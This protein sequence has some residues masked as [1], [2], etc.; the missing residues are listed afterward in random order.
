MHHC[1]MCLHFLTGG[2]LRLI[3]MPGYGVDAFLS[4][5]RLEEVPGLPA[6]SNWRELDVEHL[7]LEIP[8]LDH[9]PVI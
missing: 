3:S 2:D 8:M 5:R 7:Q 6:A 4:L 1:L 9:K